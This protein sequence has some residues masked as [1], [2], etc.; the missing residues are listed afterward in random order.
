MLTIV[1]PAPTTHLTSVDRMKVELGLTDDAQSDKLLILIGEA[2]D[3]VASYCNRENFG[4]E[5]VR[6]TDRLPQCCEVIVLDRDLAPEI[7]TVKE[8]GISLTSDQYELDGSL[9]YRL[10]N[11]QR[12]YWSAGKCEIEYEAGFIL[13]TTLP[14]GIERACVDTVTRLYHGAGRDSAVRSDEVD[15]IGQRQYFDRQSDALSAESKTALA[16]WRRVTIG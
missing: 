4:R 12:S 3:I 11:D 1:T 7:L 13:L 10:V 14:Q 2:S 15:G 5:T 16:G 9:L 8:A 6:Q